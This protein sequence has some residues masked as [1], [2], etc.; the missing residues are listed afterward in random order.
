[1]PGLIPDGACGEQMPADFTPPSCS[2]C[3]TVPAS[4]PDNPVTAVMTSKDHSH[5]ICST[6][7]LEFVS[8][9]ADMARA[10]ASAPEGAALN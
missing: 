1:M 7:A 4:G 5:A 3:G 10:L 8:T 6:C 9:L 2:F